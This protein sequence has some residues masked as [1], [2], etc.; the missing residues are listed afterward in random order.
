[1]AWTTGIGARGGGAKSDLDEE[2]LFSVLAGTV[3]GTV[4]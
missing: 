3:L 2:I 1:M 4:W